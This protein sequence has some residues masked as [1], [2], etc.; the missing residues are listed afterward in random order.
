[1]K[2][3]ILILYWPM[4]SGKSTIAKLFLEKIPG[5]FHLSWDKIKRM[6]SQYTPEKYM[7]FMNSIMVDVAQS[8]IKNWFPILIEWNVWLQ[9]EVRKKYES[10]AKEN[11]YTF[12]EINIEAPLEILE[13]RFTER[14][15]TAIEKWSRLTV[16][17]IDQ[18][19]SRYNG[20]MKYK[21]NTILTL[22]SSTLSSEEIY[23]HIVKIITNNE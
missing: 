20:Y 18:M 11:W 23:N 4:C 16:T 17:T 1:M 12:I 7:G 10:L 2:K 19:M 15:N 5:V 21:K 3:Y 9:N 14:V 6:I 13:E 22:D 8:A